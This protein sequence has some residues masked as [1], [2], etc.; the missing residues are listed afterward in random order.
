MKV[1]QERFHTLKSISNVRKCCGTF[2]II[3]LTTRD[4]KT[5]SWNNSTVVYS[6]WNYEYITKPL[7]VTVKLYICARWVP[8]SNLDEVTGYYDR[9]FGVLLSCCI[10]ITSERLVPRPSNFTLSEF[11]LIFVFN[12]EIAVWRWLFVFSKNPYFMPQVEWTVTS[13]ELY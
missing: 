8:S 6:I 5:I 1:R 9:I 7:D 11:I 10:E 4:E 3:E 13:T 12:F 2:K